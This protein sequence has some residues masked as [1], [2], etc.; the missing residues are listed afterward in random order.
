MGVRDFYAALSVEL[1]GR[2]GPWVEVSCFAP[3]HDHDRNPSCGVNLEHGRF[4]LSGMRGEGRCLWVAMLD[5]HYAGV[6]A[7]WNGKQTPAVDQINQAR[8]DIRGQRKEA[9]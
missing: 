5:R 2:P 6:L 7:N 3:D 4:Q 9:L 1:P 8:E